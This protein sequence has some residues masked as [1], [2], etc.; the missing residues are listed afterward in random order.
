[1]FILADEFGNRL[2]GAGT[3]N[4]SRTAL[5]LNAE[6]IDVHCDWWG[7]TDRRRV[8][9]AEEAFERLWED[10]VRHLRVLTLPEAVR[11]RLLRLAEGIDW[12]VEVD[13]TTALP[14]PVEPPSVLERLRFAVLRD[15]PKMPGGRFVGMETAP[16]APWP[17]QAV[18]VR[19]L[20]D[21]W[22]Y[23]YL[24]CDEVGLGKTIEAG[25]AFRSLYLSG[26]VR[27]ILIVAPPSL[28]PQ[29]QRQMAAK[30]LLPFGIARTAPEISHA[31]IFPAE[32]VRRSRLLYE[33]DLVIMSSGLLAREERAAALQ[34]AA[35]FDVALVDEAHAARRRNPSAGAAASPDYGHLYTCLRN[36]LRP[37][38]KSLWLATA[39]PMQI[40]P[41]EVSD[42]LA[43]TN[44]VG[45][46][47]F[48]PTLTLQ[49]YEV[50]G[51]IARH[52]EPSEDEW[53]F[54]RRSVESVRS[55]DPPLWR[56]IEEAVI[57][58]RLRAAAYKWLE[59][60]YVPRGRDRELLRRLI[61]S[62][63]PASRVML[64]HTRRLLEVYRENGQLKENLARR[65]IR[66]VPKI[67]FTPKERR[68]YES[69]EEYC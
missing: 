63:A 20:I 11:Q 30:L 17:H 39:T 64:R 54:L 48:D 22:P 53:E 45:A 28:M 9:E 49:Y 18:V 65:Y 21:T 58:G 19:R 12:P 4:E 10:R 56:F 7:E 42:L 5:V 67:V 38:A 14:R 44:R 61:F 46:F 68:A 66:P 25:L 52:E 16:V 57:D 32:E 26:L 13:G 8:E 40:D 15:A 33:P 2:Y 37:R 23:S 1:W 36:Y 24:L 47:Q 6:N 43:L 55:Q 51:K 59:Y 69:L 35:P 60:G 27:R 62:A 3:L 34:T 50:L 41:V 31:Y 29:W